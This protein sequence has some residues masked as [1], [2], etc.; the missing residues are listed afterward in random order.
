MVDNEIEMLKAE[1]TE[2]KNNDIRLQENI[3]TCAEQAHQELKE[4]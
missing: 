1:I 4:Y 3:N 2:L